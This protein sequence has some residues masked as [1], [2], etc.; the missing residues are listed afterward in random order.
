M[1]AK[2][3]NVEI[4]RTCCYGCPT[5]GC[6][7]QAHIEDGKLVKVTPDY[8]LPCVPN[9]QRGFL[10]NDGIAAI[11]YHNNSKRVNY[12][13]KRVGERGEGKWERVSWEQALDE[14][15]DKLNELKD[16]HSPHCISVNTGTAHHSDNNWVPQ[17]FHT[18][19]RSVNHTGHEG[20][21]YGAK[22]V[23]SEHTFGW[24]TS[25]YPP[26]G[27][28]PKCI[29]TV[30]NAYMTLPGIYLAIEQMKA[31]GTKLIS[32]DP[33]MTQ[34]GRIAD[35][36]L[37]V[38]PGSDI[39]LLQSWI[40]LMI[41]NEWYDKEFVE[42]WTNSPFL[43]R[44][45]TGKMLRANAVF[46]GA[47]DEDYVVYNTNTNAPAH[48]NHDTR[49]YEEENVAQALSGTYTLKLVDGTPVE[50]T[51]AWDKLA[52]RVDEWTPEK[53]EDVT[54]VPK[55]KIIAA[56]EMF[57]KNTP[58]FFLVAHTYDSFAPGSSDVFRSSDIMKA[59]TGTIDRA[60]VLTGCYDTNLCESIYDM[61]LRP[62]EVFT[63]EEKAK[64]VGSDRFKAISFPGFDEKVRWQKK[65]WGAATNAMWSCQAHHQFIWDDLIDDKPDRVRAFLISGSQPF[66][67]YSNV[68]KVYQAM[69][70]LDLIVTNEFVMTPTAEISDYV[71]PMSDWFERAEVGPSSP[72]DIFNFLHVSDA[73]VEPQ[74]ER[75]SDYF[76]FRELA[77]RMG[78]GDKFPWK[79]LREAYNW[80]V[81]GT[82]KKTGC[83]D[84][85]EYSQKIGCDYPEPIYEQYKQK[86]G[87]ATPT[88]KCEFWSIMLEKLG[89]DPLP[90]HRE[91]A[92]SPYSRPDLLEEYPLI[93][94]GIDRHMPNYHSMYFE[95][96]HLRAKYPDPYM[97]ISHITA[98]A[99]D[100]PIS[101][102]DWVWIE[103]QR[104]RIKQRARLTEDMHPGVVKTCHHWWFPEKPG[105]A[106]GLHGMWESNT[107]V[108]TDD[109]PEKCDPVFGSFPV[110]HL[111]CKVYK[112]EEGDEIDYPKQ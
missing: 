83:K 105:E 20:I 90:V 51:T 63:D 101:D 43:V 12:P 56:C 66:L 81:R 68:K 67:K 80:R 98:R 57:A 93:L 89:Y 109:N 78:A 34:Q 53:A 11:E 33:R 59:L 1:E 72:N 41:K 6:F 22:I 8:E 39:A 5:S 42:E 64:Q 82:L 35:L 60:E 79:N 38:R 17:R 25:L 14:I 2:M 40:R 36:W 61:E 13:L 70:K 110:G 97:E 73:V 45:D 28:E 74:F 75:K 44:N 3:G 16:K 104:G 47:S 26:P 37:Q 10:E 106:P 76:V 29:A 9:C 54:W 24:P 48:W 77:I 102:G 19:I 31:T 32:I 91:P 108:L 84:I 100:P 30:L 62:D 111:L 107:N 50:C 94:I 15:G 112:V 85:G 18:A 95:V 92:E 27:V 52:E 86:G 88:G 96:P 65:H 71:L 69:M 49:K 103:S 87:F 23:S 21:C 99:M 46:E 7:V 58:G 4:K 55:D